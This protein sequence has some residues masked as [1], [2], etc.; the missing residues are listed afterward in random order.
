MAHSQNGLM[1]AQV[2]TTV[3]AERSVGGKKDRHSN[4]RRI[5]I[6]H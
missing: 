3:I 6:L 5:F 1:R 4:S 2:V